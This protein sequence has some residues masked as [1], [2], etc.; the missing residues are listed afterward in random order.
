MISIVIM[1]GGLD[2]AVV[3]AKAIADNLDKEHNIY[4]FHVKQYSRQNSKERAALWR[5]L[6]QFKQDLSTHPQVILNPTKFAEFRAPWLDSHDM[7]RTHQID[8]D[9]TIIVP[10]RNFIILSLACSYAMQIS[11]SWMRDVHVWFG[12]DHSGKRNSKQPKDKSPWFVKSCFQAANDCSEA[13]K[14]IP[15][16]PLQRLFKDQIIQLGIEYKAPMEMTW[17]CYNKLKYHCGKCSA[18]QDRIQ[19][20]ENLCIKDPT[21]YI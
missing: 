8:L 5:T 19:G 7:H 11:D 12:F 10:A 2:S 1:S 4:P 16:A 9:S 6:D 3:L 15:H 14:L 18:C 21:K 13:G 20:Y 17:S